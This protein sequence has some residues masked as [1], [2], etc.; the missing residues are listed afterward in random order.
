MLLSKTVIIKWN[1]KIKKHYEDLGYV[2]TKMGDSF[3]V[4]IND[5][6]SG[7]NVV[8]DVEC[9]YCHRVY[10]TPWFVYYKSKNKLIKND[11]CNNPECTGKKAQDT[12]KQ[13]YNVSNIRQIPNVNKKIV[14]TNI[15]RYGVKNPFESKE[16]KQ[17]IKDTNIRKYGVEWYTQTEEFKERYKQTCLEKYGVP[18][19]SYTDEFIKMMSG[20][21]SPVWKGADIKIPR[22]W[23]RNSSEYKNWRNTVFVRDGYTCQCCGAH[24]GNGKTVK[25]VAHH[26]QNWS[27]CIEL[28]YDK[29]NGI[30]LCDDCHVDFH[31]VYGIKN[32]NREQLNEFI[33]LNNKKEL[34][35]KIC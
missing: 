5:L 12:I 14:E 1:P 28:R 10:Q 26:I 2:Y 27:S 20:E 23:Y 35:E 6:T 3:E 22:E 17:K 7:S 13:K 4:D 31:S 18:N 33:S 8:V 34:D 30:T 11:C 32:N 15:E 29:E 21:N 9:D 24:S 25:L 16:I 19:Y